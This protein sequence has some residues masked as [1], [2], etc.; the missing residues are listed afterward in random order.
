VPASA[1]KPSLTNSLSP[2]RSKLDIHLL[3]MQLRLK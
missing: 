2:C 1:H 3:Q